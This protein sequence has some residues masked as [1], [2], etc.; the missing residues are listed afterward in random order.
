MKPVSDTNLSRFVALDLHKHYVVV[1]AVNR[2]QEVVLKPRRLTIG[3]LATWAQANLLPSDQVV[4]EATG[5]AWTVHDLLS[6]LVQGCLVADA[7]QVKWI[8]H[9]AVKT[10]K[11]DVLR[12]AKLLAARLIPEVWV[13]PQPVRELRALI[14]HRT[15]LVRAQTRVKNQLQSVIHRFSLQPPKG[16]VFA[17]K[18]R[19]WWLDLPLSSTEALRL[20]Q[21]MRTLDHL[22][23]ELTEV[24]S[25]LRHLSTC[26]LW[27]DFVPYLVQLPGRRSRPTP[28]GKHSSNAS[29]ATSTRT[30]P[31]SPSHAGCWSP[32]GMCSASGWP[33]KTLS[34]R[35]WPSS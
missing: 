11:Q 29:Y 23:Q 7:R 15:S 31:L 32:F 2:D 25:E 14:A 27:K 1:A 26:E 12:L 3:G 4:I 13:P 30:K 18:N 16:Q 10:D 34:R 9:A 35:W 22:K 28:T 24:E 5:N 19:E 33:T 17:D 6:P 8:A 20:R 21:N